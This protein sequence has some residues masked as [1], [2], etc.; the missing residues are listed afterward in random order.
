MNS[1]SSWKEQEHPPWKRQQEAK[2]MATQR[3]VILLSEIQKGVNI[4]KQLPQKYS[5]L[6][7]A[8]ALKTAK[9]RLT[10]LDLH[11]KRYTR[12]AENK[13]INRMF[14]NNLLKVYSRWQGSEVAGDPLMAEMEQYWKNIWEKE[15]T[16]NTNAQWLV[17]LQVENSNFPATSQIKTQ[18][19]SQWQTSRKECQK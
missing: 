7:T 13:R 3:E 1:N 11:L 12:E 8:E 16:H 9:E 4:Q 10:V 18:Q 14:S 15:M 17:D 19:S 5:K 2:I 6:S